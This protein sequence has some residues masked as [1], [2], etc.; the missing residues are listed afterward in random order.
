MTGQTANYS[1]NAFLVVGDV[2]EISLNVLLNHAFTVQ[3]MR[4]SCH[5]QR[6]SQGLP[7]GQHLSDCMELTVRVATNDNAKVFL[8]CMADNQPHA[9][10]ILYDVSFT[11]MRRLSDYEDAMIARGYVVDVEEEYDK[12]PHSDGLADQMLVRVSLLLSNLSYVGRTSK[13]NL[14]I[15]ND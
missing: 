1:L 6:N 11:K 10:S 9:F 4:Y 7:Y 13:L 2:T 8:D 14:T 5:R 12:D 15:S 3:Q